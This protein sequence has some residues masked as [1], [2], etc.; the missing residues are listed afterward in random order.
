MNKLLLTG[1]FLAVSILAG[2]SGQP[3]ASDLAEDQ[4]KAEM[5]RFKAKM[6]MDELK[7]KKL[8]AELA[9]YP[10]WTVSPPRNDA[11]GVFGVGVGVDSNIRIA[12]QKAK[13]RAEY[14]VAKHFKQLLSGSEKDYAVSVSDN[15]ISQKYTQ[16][17]DKLVAEVPVVGYD[18]VQHEVKG[19]NGA[20]HSFVMIKMPYEEFNTALQALRGNDQAAGFDE[21]FSE[22]ERRIDKLKSTPSTQTQAPQANQVEAPQPSADPGVQV[23]SRLNTQSN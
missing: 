2:C 3:S 14:E 15:T 20:T 9:E 12:Q 16:A 22:L 19:I 13:L 7:Q 8:K 4:A 5:I 21:A 11:T 6:E 1:S 17:I 18:V 23:I 10:K